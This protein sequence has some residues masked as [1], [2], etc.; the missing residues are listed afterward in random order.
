[1]RGSLPCCKGF[2]KSRKDGTIQ[3]VHQAYCPN[4]TMSTKK[5]SLIERLL[6]WIL[7]G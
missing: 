1:M 7:C 4:E 2:V 5:L 6:A 3:V